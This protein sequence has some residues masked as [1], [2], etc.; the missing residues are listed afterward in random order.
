MF[1][2][3]TITLTYLEEVF[4]IVISS[5]SLLNSNV[6]LLLS[7]KVGLRPAFLATAVWFATAVRLLDSRE[8]ISNDMDQPLVVL[9]QVLSSSGEVSRLQQLPSLLFRPTHSLGPAEIEC[10][11][12]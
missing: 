5:V 6:L 1:A 12:K 7:V 8:W 11:S 4:V 9:K 3:S 2:S 10:L